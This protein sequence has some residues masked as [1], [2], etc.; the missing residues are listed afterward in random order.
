MKSLPDVY[1]IPSIIEPAVASGLTTI[2]LIQNG[3]GIE[4]PFIEAFPENKILS[5]V[6]MIGCELNGCEVLHNDPDIL[7][8]GHFP[9]L[10]SPCSELEN[11]SSRF[12]KMYESGGAKCVV[13]E[14]ILWHR[15]RRLV[16]NAPFNSIC[17][18]TNV[19]SGTILDTRCKETLIRRAMN[20][21]VSLAAAAGYV[22]PDDIQ[23]Q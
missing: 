15:W 12:S 9:R 20:E 7:Y 16:W 1:S 11:T 8:L 10:V 13:V 23:E 21:I 18:L 4:Q 6:T 22:L 3:I 5:G 14:D 17:A 19:D 2:V